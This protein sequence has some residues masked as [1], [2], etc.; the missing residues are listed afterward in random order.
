L[1]L[2]GFGFESGATRAPGRVVGLW[3]GWK[4]TP[5]P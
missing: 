5:V 1:L 4:W 2:G 3:K